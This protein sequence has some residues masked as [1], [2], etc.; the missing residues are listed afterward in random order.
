MDEDRAL[1]FKQFQGHLN[2]FQTICAALLLMSFAHQSDA[3]QLYKWV[4]EKGEV[5]F[6]DEIPPDAAKKTHDIVN[7]KGMVVK[8]VEATKTKEQ[9]LEAEKQ[10]RKHDAAKNEANKAAKLRVERDN[11]LL[12]TYMSEKDL[13]DTRDR[14]INTIEA[15]IG[16]SSNS[17]SRIKENLSKLQKN[18]N[19]LASNK[20]PISDDLKGDIHN[21][22]QQL[23]NL[24]R[25]INEKRAEQHKLRDKFSADLERFRQLK[26]TEQADNAR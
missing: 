25:F 12:D 6:S 1:F 4:N 3:K 9:L 11:A 21:L 5:Y 14:Q 23:A 16:I 24:E 22:K 19:A 2:F 17:A 8:S 20:K 26:A 10:A 18:A 7:D 15:N 13:I